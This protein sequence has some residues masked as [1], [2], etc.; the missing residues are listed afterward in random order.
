MQWNGE[1]NHG[2]SDSDKP[3]LPTDSRPDA[4]TVEKQK[5][6]PDSLLN[7]TKFIVNLHKS[8]KALCPDA[9]FEIL[10][11][12]Y[13]F[14]FTRKTEDSTICVCINPSQYDQALTDPGVKEVL[15]SQNCTIA[16]GKVNMAGVSLLIARI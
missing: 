2:F 14:V 10:R 8:E 7:F 1:K 12:G 13:P 15:Y 16:D 6:V 3:Y 5:D 4:P 11:A 9:D